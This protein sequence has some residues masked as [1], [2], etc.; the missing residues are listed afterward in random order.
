MQKLFA[1]AGGVI[2]ASLMVM[3]SVYAGGLTSPTPYTDIHLLEPV[4][5]AMTIDQAPLFCDD[6]AGLAFKAPEC[7]Q[8]VATAIA[9]IAPDRMPIMGLASSAPTIDTLAS[10]PYPK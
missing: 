2:V 1:L 7:S 3:G 6:L 10:H 4:P 9:S 8:R 5:I